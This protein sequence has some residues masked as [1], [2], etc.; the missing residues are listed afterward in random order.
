MAQQCQ[1][2][3]LARFRHSEVTGMAE[4]LREDISRHSIYDHDGA[5]RG[6]VGA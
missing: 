3:N 5:E 2:R 4:R 6:E 1:V